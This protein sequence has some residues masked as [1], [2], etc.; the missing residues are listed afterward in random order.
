[1]TIAASHSGYM[2]MYCSVV[3]TYMCVCTRPIM[4]YNIPVV[5]LAWFQ[6]SIYISV[7]HIT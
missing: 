7:M 3:H 2:Y 1:M 4:Y 6:K 5:L